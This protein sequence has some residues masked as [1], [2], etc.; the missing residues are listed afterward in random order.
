MSKFIAIIPARGGSKRIPRKNIRSFFGKPII[1]YAIENLILTGLFDEIIVSTDDIEI[2]EIAKKF[3]AKVPF[4]R[5]EK[6]SSDIA[7]TNDV[8]EEVL[9][10]YRDNSEI[11]N[12]CLCLYPCTPLLDFRNINK[13]FDLLISKN[14]DSVI[15]VVKYSTPIERSFKFTGDNIQLVNPEMLLVRSQDLEPRYFDA[16]QFYFFNTDSF[17][18]NNQILTSNSS[19][20]ELNELEVQDIDNVVDWELAE[21]KYQLKLKE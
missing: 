2:A 5:S 4:L 9:S 21:L 16:G 19:A 3:G 6:N 8:I 17:F 7:S 11:F 15:S 1:A 14:L 10:Y 20:V 12:Y 18:Q 13:A